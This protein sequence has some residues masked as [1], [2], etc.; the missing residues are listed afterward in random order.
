MD[1]FLKHYEGKTNVENEWDNIKNILWKTAEK[2][3]WN[4]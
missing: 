3:L 1:D 4:I 2:S